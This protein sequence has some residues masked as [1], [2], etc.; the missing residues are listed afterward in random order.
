MSASAGMLVLRRKVGLN[1]VWARVTASA[2]GNRQSSISSSQGNAAIGKAVLRAVKNT[3]TVL[4]DILDRKIEVRIG[5]T[6][7]KMSVREAIL[8][9]FAEAALKGDTKSAA[10]LLQR[11]DMIEIRPG[12]RE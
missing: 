2:T 8:T 11:Y 3:F 1:L 7:R 10:F 5:G 9:R 6:L 4:R 12:A